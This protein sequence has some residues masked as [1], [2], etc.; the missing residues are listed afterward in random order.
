MVC[1]VQLCLSLLIFC[2]A[3][4]TPA[5]SSARLWWS[6]PL[7]CC[8]IHSLES[9]ANGLEHIPTFPACPPNWRL[10]PSVNILVD[11]CCTPAPARA[12]G[13]APPET[14]VAGV[15]KRSGSRTRGDV[16]G[17]LGGCWAVGR[18]I[19]GAARPGPI[20]SGA[21]PGLCALSDTLF[22][23]LIRRSVAQKKFRR[24]SMCLLFL[25]FFLSTTGEA[26]QVVTY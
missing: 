19:E 17:P 6:S 23:L 4:S 18:R 22:L 21:G 24:S 9:A 16:R 5:S 7:A 3:R 13:A 20:S 8:P 10:S 11:L 26:V 12:H 2:H 1:P 14:G 15:R 25:S